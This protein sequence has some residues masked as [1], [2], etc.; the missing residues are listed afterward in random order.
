[1]RLLAYRP[2]YGQ[3]R[4]DD[5]T[6]SSL[7]AK[8]GAALKARGYTLALAE[9][10]T[11]GMVAQEIT[12]IAGSS[13]WFDRGFVTYSNQAKIEMLGVSCKTLDTYGAVSEQTA[14]EMAL[15]A[16]KNSHAHVSG[17]IT[18]IAG[19]DGGTPEKPVGAVCFAWS[20]INKPTSTT[21]KHFE[22]NREEIR[23]QAT[24]EMMAGLIDRLKLSV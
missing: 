8:L 4:M 16:L 22:G 9:S 15:G 11:G 2:C 12:N 6:L 17:S 24:I 23:Q 18:G 5:V 20:E 21:T 1:M 7:A 13:A 14:N 19:P 3:L 10:C